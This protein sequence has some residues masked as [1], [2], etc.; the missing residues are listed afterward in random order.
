MHLKK[1]SRTALWQAHGT[2]QGVNQAIYNKQTQIPVA[3]CM[4]SI[5]YLGSIIL[6]HEILSFQMPKYLPGLSQAVQRPPNPPSSVSS[7]I[8]GK[9]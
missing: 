1:E 9:E 5:I 8:N 2:E 7:I 3:L 4:V 6:S